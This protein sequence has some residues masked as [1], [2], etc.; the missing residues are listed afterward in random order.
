MENIFYKILEDKDE[1]GVG[2]GWFCYLHSSLS[3]HVYVFICY[4]ISNAFV[5]INS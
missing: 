5:E 1:E 4:L 2:G 3:L